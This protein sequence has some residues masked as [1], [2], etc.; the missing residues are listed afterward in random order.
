MGMIISAPPRSK[1]REHTAVLQ[2]LTALAECLLLLVIMVPVLIAE[3]EIRLTGQCQ[4][5]DLVQD[6]IHPE[7][8]NDVFDDTLIL[9]AAG[10]LR[11]GEFDIDLLVGS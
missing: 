8:L 9:V 10:V 2:K 6:R 7:T 11:G 5:W 3:H 4:Q 1:L